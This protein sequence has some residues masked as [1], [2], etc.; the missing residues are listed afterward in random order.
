ML[1]EKFI[2]KIIPMIN[3][4]GA[5]VGNNRT[6]LL[7]K[8]L[9]RSYLEANQKM[10]PE[11]YHVRH[12]VQS[13]MREQNDR[14]FAFF[15]LHQH[16]SRKSIFMYAPYFPLHSRKYLKIR[17]L[18]KLLAERS[19]MFRYYSCKFKYE[20]Q[21]EGCARLSLWKDFNL[22]NS[23]TLECSALGY[24]NEQRETIPFTEESLQEFGVLFAHSLCEFD[25]IKE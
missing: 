6:S 7:G 2:F 3:P 24:L 8:D 21:K 11:I 19:P 1:R 9:N 14:L 12:L 18:P 17:M 10:N 13:I 15:D 22:E 16:S 20:R 25:L 4:D 23:Y 5:I